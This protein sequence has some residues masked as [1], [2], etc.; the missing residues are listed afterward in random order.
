MHEMKQQS[1]WSQGVQISQGPATLMNA[2]W[3]TLVMINHEPKVK[4]LCKV[5]YLY[6][7]EKVA[8]NRDGK[9]HDIFGNRHREIVLEEMHTEFWVGFFCL[10]FVCFGFL[11]LCF[12]LF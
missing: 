10:V 4:Y 7:P 2:L 9:Q 11:F 12:V 3:E 1:G 5:K 8:L 6:S